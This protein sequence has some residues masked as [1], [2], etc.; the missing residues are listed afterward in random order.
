[1]VD[2]RAAAVAL[3]SA[4]VSTGLTA[5]NVVLLAV[6]ITELVLADILLEH[7]HVDLVLL[8]CGH[9]AKVLGAPAGE[10]SSLVAEIERA[11]LVNAGRNDVLVIQSDWTVEL[12][13]G[14]IVAK[15]NEFDSFSKNK[16]KQANELR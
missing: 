9:A 8:S 14:N 5:A 12:D 10:Q 1:L 2:K 4:T 3:A 11:G 13:D 16:Q 6:H 7:V 15:V